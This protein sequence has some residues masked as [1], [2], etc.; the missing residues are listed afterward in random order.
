MELGKGADELV[1]DED[2]VLDELSIDF[3]KGVDE[4]ID[5]FDGVYP[6]DVDIDGQFA[7]QVPCCSD[8]GDVK[9][10]HPQ[11]PLY[12]GFA[13]AFNFQSLTPGQHTMDVHVYSKFGDHHVLSTT[14]TSESMG[15]YAF[16]KK[17]MFDDA[18]AEDHFA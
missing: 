17:F 12:S 14:F 10:A 16:N 6:F 18:K 13:G 3:G 5:G 9:A 7:F 11:A 1:L 2:T 15:S 8:R 4:F